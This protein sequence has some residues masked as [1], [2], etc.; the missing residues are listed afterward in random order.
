MARASKDGKKKAILGGFAFVYFFCK[1]LGVGGWI[2][3][4]T[5]C[6]ARDLLEG[7]GHRQLLDS[8]SNIVGGNKDRDIK[9]LIRK[10][11]KRT[12]ATRHICI[13]IKEKQENKPTLMLKRHTERERE[14]ERE[15]RR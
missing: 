3:L 11:P 5:P 6:G 9:K 8:S 13:Y 4:H 12:W 7:K 10:P 2:H 1:G 15:A 14:R